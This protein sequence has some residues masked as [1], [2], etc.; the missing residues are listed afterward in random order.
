MG[1]HAANFKE[2]AAQFPQP[3]QSR[4]N[5]MRRVIL[6]VSPNAEES[7]RYGMPSFKVGNV[8][9][10]MAG[11]KHHIGMYPMPSDPEL[12]K[13]ISRYRAPKT[14]DSIHFKHKD[15]LPLDVIKSVAV[16]QWKRK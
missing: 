6:S 15:E 16:Y 1:E 8:H 14:K 10:Y 12:E 9:L 11:Y 4:L 7:I 2:Y 3:V 13:I 5:Q